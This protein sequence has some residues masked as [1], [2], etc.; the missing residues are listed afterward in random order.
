[1]ITNIKKLF[2]T[3]NRTIFKSS[4]EQNK[5]E[6]LKSTMATDLGLHVTMCT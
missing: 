1:M 6:W 4:L 2:S 3:T 5:V